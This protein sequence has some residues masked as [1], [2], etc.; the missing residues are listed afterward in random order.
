M[1][2]RKHPTSARTS[3]T[4]KRQTTAGLSPRKVAPTGSN[5]ASEELARLRQE[6]DVCKR[7]LSETL[8]QQAATGEI[9][10]ASSRS[11]GDMQP[12]LDAVAE[13]A[14]RLCGANDVLIRRVE[15][16]LAHV[17]AHFGPVPILRS[18]EA[19]PITAANFIG[20]A[21]LERRTIHI[22]D[23]HEPRVREEY[24]EA[25]LYLGRFRTILIAPL[26]RE[27]TA[28]G[29]IVMRRQEARLFSDRQVELLQTFAAQAAI[30]IENVRLFNE[31]KEALEQ[32][33]AT[34]EILKVISSSPTDIQPVFDAILEN[35]TRLCGAHMG[36]L[37]L[38]DGQTYRRVAQRGGSAEFARWL[39]EEG[40]KYPPDPHGVVTQM[41]AERRP[42]HILDRREQPA[43]L[44]RNPSPRLRWSNWE[45]RGHPS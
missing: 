1:A 4:R 37:G 39:A 34:A 23:T 7:E 13:S 25:I 30:A 15:G 45:E 31:T 11:P 29:A 14:A 9:L 42:I 35:A 2:I 22:E 44:E 18:R 12:V 27:D 26:L 10:R 8:D 38:Y 43:Y 32:Q 40:P 19:I 3:G 20:R 5:G 6:L 24:P 36:I 16:N 21:V 28:I 17:V 33:T 41:I